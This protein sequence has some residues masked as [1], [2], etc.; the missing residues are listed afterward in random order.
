MF[1]EQVFSV[2]DLQHFQILKMVQ[3]VGRVLWCSTTTTT[4]TVIARR[5]LQE[6]DVK[7]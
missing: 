4:A 5:A 3:K 2:S 6:A 1:A 7:L